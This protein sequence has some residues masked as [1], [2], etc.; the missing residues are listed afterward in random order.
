MI[1]VDSFTGEKT[2]ER[3]PNCWQVFDHLYTILTMGDTWSGKTNA[4]LNQRNY[5]PDINK[6][7]YALK[8]HTKQNISC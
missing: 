3:N 6:I 4:L 1:N 2:E 5:Q 7:I 8:N